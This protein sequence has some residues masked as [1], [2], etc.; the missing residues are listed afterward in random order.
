MNN[1][2]DAI[3]KSSNDTH[4]EHEQKIRKSL[5]IKQKMGK[6]AANVAISEPVSLLYIPLKIIKKA[7]IRF[8]GRFKL[9]NSDQKAASTT[10]NGLQIPFEFKSSN[11]NIHIAPVTKV[12]KRMNGNDTKNPKQIVLRSLKLG[13][14]TSVISFITHTT[15]ST[16][17]DSTSKSQSTHCMSQNN[18]VFFDIYLDF[19]EFTFF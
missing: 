17:T 15:S 8:F 3:S 19:C 9:Q 16:I 5:I 6:Y 11:T 4:K 10:D 14:S 2:Y 7:E 12:N 1:K 18:E 13:G